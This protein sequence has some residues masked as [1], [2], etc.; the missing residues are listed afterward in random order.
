MSGLGRVRETEWLELK[1]QDIGKDNQ[2][3]WSSM[4]VAKLLDGL[5]YNPVVYFQKLVAILQVVSRCHYAASHESHLFMLLPLCI[6]RL[7]EGNMAIGNILLI[8][9]V[10]SHRANMFIQGSCDTPAVMSVFG[11]FRCKMD[12]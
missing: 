7:E 8:I 1:L 6:Y 4:N 2:T 3:A 11:V 10:Q 9:A 12:I 5:K